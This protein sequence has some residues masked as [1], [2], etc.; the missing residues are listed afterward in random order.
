L[1]VALLNL[2]QGAYGEINYGFLSAGAVVAMIPCV[3]LF[4]ALQRYYVAGM[5]AGAVKG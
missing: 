2:Q 5:A 3:V 4:L 1:P